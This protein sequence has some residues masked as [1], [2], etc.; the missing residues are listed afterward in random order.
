MNCIWS[1]D[2]IVSTHLYNLSK[3]VFETLKQGVTMINFNIGNTKHTRI[4][5]SDFICNW[6]NVLL[7]SINSLTVNFFEWND[8][9]YSISFV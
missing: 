9:P 6:V 2:I 4:Y 3:K 8:I 1:E 5:N 7:N